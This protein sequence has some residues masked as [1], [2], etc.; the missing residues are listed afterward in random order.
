V[1]PRFL[2]VPQRMGDLGGFGQ[3]IMEL[4]I[5]GAHNCESDKARLTCLL[6]DRIIA[7]DAGG[8]T[9]TLS[10]DDQRRLKAV[11]VTHHHF[12]HIRDLSTL[13][14]NIYTLGPLGIYALKSTLDVISTYIF[15]G[16]LYPDFT[17][18]PSLD[19]PAF[20][21]NPIAPDKAFA[22]EGYTVIPFAVNHGV[23]TIGYQITSP[24]NKRLVYTGDTCRNPESTWKG[25]SPQLIVT[26]VTV[27]N[28]YETAARES[29]HLTPQ[30]LK[31]ELIDFKKANGYIPPV[32]AVHISPHLE[33]EIRQEI[34]RVADELGTK[35]TCGH[36]G[37]RITVQ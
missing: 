32:V 20:K 31:E 4:T 30:L 13:G 12:D 15:N 36:E 24:D 11:L 14:M 5:L 34:A 27:C 37:I 10:I 35:I 22:V 18:K 16:T 28:A 7:I 1:S 6:V 17:K 9:S 8:L 23:P 33:N 19:K 21:F 2:K 29:R 25:L 26:E 3:T